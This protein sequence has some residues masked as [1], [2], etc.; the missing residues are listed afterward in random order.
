MT[1]ETFKRQTYLPVF[2]GVN[3]FNNWVPLLSWNL[4]SSTRT[5]NEFGTE[6][7]PS[8]IRIDY[9]YQAMIFVEYNK[10]IIILTIKKTTTTTIHLISTN[11]VI[12]FLLFGLTHEKLLRY[13]T[14][15]LDL[16]CWYIVHL[17][18]ELGSLAF[19]S[20]FVS[21]FVFA[22][23]VTN[24]RKQRKKPW[25]HMYCRTLIGHYLPVVA[26]A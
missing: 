1:G 5:G 15:W 13:K 14:E 2:K 8:N 23:S 9:K 11:I 22:F 6:R 24:I 26:I 7:F 25:I 12:N 10:T 21:S 17:F 18:Q 16:H 20:W 4:W 19:F 3:G